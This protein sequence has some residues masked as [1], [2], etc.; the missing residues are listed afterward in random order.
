MGVLT[1]VAVS[2]SQSATA[3]VI[4]KI[5]S[6]LA[7]SLYL[8]KKVIETVCGLLF[9]AAMGVLFFAIFILPWL[10]LAY[11]LMSILFIFA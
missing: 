3:T 7:T 5:T 1:N 4:P 2:Y 9:F 8:T 6:L 10:F 11:F